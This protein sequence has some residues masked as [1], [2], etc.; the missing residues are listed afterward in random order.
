MPG[1]PVFR[2]RFTLRGFLPGRNAPDKLNVRLNPKDLGSVGIGVT[3]REWMAVS[4]ASRERGVATERWQTRA[5]R[6]WSPLPIRA[7]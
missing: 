6:A 7:K 5:T 1:G 3:V 2:H 4:G